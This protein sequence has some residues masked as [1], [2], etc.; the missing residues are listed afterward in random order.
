MSRPRA[1][2]WG[3]VLAAV[4][5]FACTGCG[6]AVSVSEGSGG[7]KVSAHPLSEVAQAPKPGVCSIPSPR[8]HFATGEWTAHET[9]LT[10][11][12]ADGCVG[13]QTVHPWDFRRLCKAG[14]CETYLLT[15]SLYNPLEIAPITPDGSGHYTAVFPPSTAPCPHRPGEDAGR[16]TLY[17]IITL[18]WSDDRQTLYGFRRERYVGP[19]GGGPPE[20]GSYVAVR[21]NPAANWPADGP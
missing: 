5:L 16:N 13:E 10:T 12:A 3:T 15:Q 19:C 2:L 1:R 4:L 9:I 14:R 21:T 7:L 18:W 11:D 8:A 17:G 6:E 20:T